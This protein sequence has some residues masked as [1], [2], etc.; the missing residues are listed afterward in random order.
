[1]KIIVYRLESSYS[2]NISG[3]STGKPLAEGSDS[4]S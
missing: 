3:L 1:M 2:V 4:N